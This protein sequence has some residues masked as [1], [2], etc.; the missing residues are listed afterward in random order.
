VF[1]SVGE[2]SSALQIR[3]FGTELVLDLGRVAAMI[4]AFEDIKTIRIRKERSK[5][6]VVL[7]MLVVVGSQVCPDGEASRSWGKRPSSG[8]SKH[9]AWRFALG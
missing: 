3:I 5:Q 6:T 1:C 2:V 4:S 9:V 7:G 8:P